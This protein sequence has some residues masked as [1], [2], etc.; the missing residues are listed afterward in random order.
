MLSSIKNNR[1]INFVFQS[2]KM[3]IAMGYL[4]LSW[5]Y[6]ACSQIII[7]LPFN[8]VP[9][10]IQPAPLFLATLLFGWHAVNAYVLYLAQGALGLPFFAGMLGGL[11]RLMGPTGG[12]LIGFGVAMIFLASIRHFSSRSKIIML[13]TLLCAEAITFVCGLSQLALFVPAHKLLAAGLFPFM[14]GDFLIKPILVAFFYGG[15]YKK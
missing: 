13:A 3:R 1:V 12:Y 15:F 7:P 8:L 2:P 5:F 6:A 14:I 10:S 9:M 4:A 11:G